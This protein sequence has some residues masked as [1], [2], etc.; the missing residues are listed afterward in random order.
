LPR[1]LIVIAST[2]PGRRGSAVADWFAAR[3]REHGG[4]EIEIADLAE[5]A[6]P[7]LD[8]PN[9]NARDDYIHEHTRRWSAIVAAA[10]AFVFVMP[11]YNRTFTAPL[12]N[13][14]DY[15]YY[16]WNYKPVGLVS[17]GGM[18][19]GLRAAYAIKPAL[20][21]LR[22]VPVDD[23][24]TFSDV[25]R[26]I[27][28]GQLQLDER[29]AGNAAGMLDELAKLATVLAPLRPTIMTSASAGS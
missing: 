25:R 26:R 12:K 5:L 19:G 9:D 13:A 4:F 7:L 17:Y 3:A 8:E 16:E 18:S 21:A 11:E 20:T 1:L 24:A 27:V 23:A 15:L 6:L 2:R 10:D 14:L 22:L 29:Q 28:D